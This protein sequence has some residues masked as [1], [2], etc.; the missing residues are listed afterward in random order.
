MTVELSD[1]ELAILVG[2]TSRRMHRLHDVLTDKQTKA[3]ERLRALGLTVVQHRRTNKVIGR[4]SIGDMRIR[5]EQTADRT[6]AGD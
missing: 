4:T 6:T 2:L 3:V 1:L 5:R